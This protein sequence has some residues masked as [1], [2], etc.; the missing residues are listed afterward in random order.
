MNEK[1]CNK[2]L[3]HTD[4]CFQRSLLVGEKKAEIPTT[5][6]ELLNGHCKR[7]SKDLPCIRKFGIKCLAP[8]PRTL[9]NLGYRT[10]SKLTKRICQTEAG[11]QGELP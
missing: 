1:K 2:L 8:L 3:L 5:K 6:E 7:V 9:F 11:Q 10:A 4:K